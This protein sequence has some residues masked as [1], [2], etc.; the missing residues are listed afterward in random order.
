[1]IFDTNCRNYHEVEQNIINS[2]GKD[3]EQ[4]REELNKDD[5]FSQ[6][7]FYGDLLDYLNYSIDEAIKSKRPAIR[8]MGMLDKRLGKRRLQKMNVEKE[9]TLVQRFYLMRCSTEDIR[10]DSTLEDVDLFVGQFSVYFPVGFS[11]NSHTSTLGDS[12]VSLMLIRTKLG[13]NSS[14]KP[15]G[16]SYTAPGPQKQP[17]FSKNLLY[18]SSAKHNKS[19][20]WTWISVRTFWETV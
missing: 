7:N 9:T 18:I 8:A 2:T 12:S 15:C 3:Y 5:L 1:M 4:V 6:S 19:V 11:T 14:Y 16:A 17:E 13:G 10:I 20:Y